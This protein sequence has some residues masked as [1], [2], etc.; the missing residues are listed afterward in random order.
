M[1]KKKQAQSHTEGGTVMAG[2]GGKDDKGKDK[3]GKDKKK[4]GGDSGSY[5]SDTVAIILKRDCAEA[6]YAALVI[7]LGTLPTPKKKKKDKKK[8]KKDKGKKDKG[9]D[10]GKDDKGKYDYGKGGKK[11]Y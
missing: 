10:K 8:G 11:K 3:K 7:A 5:W 4:K 9:K 6:L 2:K 1:K